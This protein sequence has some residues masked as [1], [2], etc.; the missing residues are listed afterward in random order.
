[1]KIKILRIILMILLLCTFFVIFGFSSQDG[2]TSGGLSQKITKQFLEK[3]KKYNELDE[4]DKSVISKRLEKVVRKI[5]HF[6]IYALVGFL[7]MGIMCTYKIKIKWGIIITL[8]LGIIYA[9]SDEIHQGFTPGRSPKVTDIYIDTLGVATGSL[10]IVTIQ[11]IYYKYITKIL[12]KNKNCHKKAV[13]K[14]F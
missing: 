12:Q 7:L 9:T 13:E 11:K 5:A 10:V 14:V 6:S 3:F 8:M 4:N 1:M 2:E